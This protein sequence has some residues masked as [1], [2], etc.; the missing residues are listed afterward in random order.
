M[1]LYKKKM[2]LCLCQCM[3][4]LVYY[5]CVCVC[6]CVCVFWTQTWFFGFFVLLGRILQ[7]SS[8]MVQLK[9][10]FSQLQGEVGKDCKKTQSDCKKAFRHTF[11]A[12]YD[13]TESKNDAHTK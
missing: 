6:A 1:T 10:W 11:E 7:M 12:L 9:V 2:Y 3:C 4:V 5:V 13:K 8:P